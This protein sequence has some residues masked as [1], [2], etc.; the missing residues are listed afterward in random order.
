MAHLPIPDYTSRQDEETAE[1]DWLG[2]AIYLLQID[3]LSNL[4][5][6]KDVMTTAD[7]RQAEAEGFN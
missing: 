5:V 4:R 2:L 7:A 6:D 3:H 1:S